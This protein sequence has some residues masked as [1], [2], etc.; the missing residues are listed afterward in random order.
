MALMLRGLSYERITSR[1]GS[2]GK[3]AQRRDA[4]GRCASG[5]CALRR[6]PD[7]DGSAQ[8]GRLIETITPAAVKSSTIAMAMTMRCCVE[9]MG[10]CSNPILN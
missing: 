1:D 3:Q 10:Q 4:E 8:Y 7:F 6:C 2:I 9:N 5:G